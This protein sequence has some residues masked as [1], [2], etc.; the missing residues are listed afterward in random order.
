MSLLELKKEII[1]MRWT[2]VLMAFMAMGCFCIVIPETNQTLKDYK[3]YFKDDVHYLNRRIDASE[4]IL[5]N[6]KDQDKNKM[7]N[8]IE[9]RVMQSCLK[10]G[11]TR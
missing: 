7:T 8:E 10:G 5:E 11:K 2:F 3:N 9:S 4:L 1:F 6:Y